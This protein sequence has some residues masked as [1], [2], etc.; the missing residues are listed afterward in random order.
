MLGAIRRS[1]AARLALALGGVLV[2][3]VG[4]AVVFS[5]LA[6]RVPGVFAGEASFRG[7][8]HLAEELAAVLGEPAA[9]QARAEWLGE[10][11]ASDVTVVAL[12]GRTLAVAGRPVPRPSPERFAEAAREMTLLPGAGPLELPVLGI[13]VRVGGEVR[14]VALVRS[15]PEAFGPLPWRALLMVGLGLGLM[16][17]LVV[18]IARS[19][20][21][22]LRR[23]AQVAG[24]FGRG[25]LAARSHI[26]RDDEVGQLA[27]AFD[28]MAERLES[29]R[30]REREV[31]A[32]VSH[33]L[34]T[35][36]AR[37]R[38]VLGLVESDDAEVER[39]LAQL[40]EELGELEGLVAGVLEASRVHLEALP[41]RPGPVALGA[42]VARSVERLRASAPERVVE[43]DVPE[44]LG[45]VADEALLGRVVDNLLDNA[46]KYDA[47]GGV[48]RVE[49]A[50]EGGTVRLRVLDRGAGIAP[51]DAERIFEPFYRA[52]AAR[53]MASGFGVGLALAR[54]VARA[55]G[56]DVRALPRP[57]GGTCMEVSLPQGRGGGRPAATARTASP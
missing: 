11:F 14:A 4:L 18:P 7:M 25:N 47:S 55:H 33:E 5:T 30:R 43:V 48:V 54:R 23:L 39:R 29:Q 38:M 35:P 28:D 42:L 56:G 53:G 9:L 36:L 15:W 57:A 20:T 21:R 31:M 17:A 34:R 50:A 1:V 24:D 19:V 6:L 8:R 10:G 13:P 37:V 2:L 41:V 32:H 12:D 27:R 22:P 16:L 40:E 49:A 52:G 3:L 26:Q 51:E 46:H 44:G 45:L